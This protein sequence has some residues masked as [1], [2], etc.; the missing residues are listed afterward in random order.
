V[1]TYTIG[2]YN[3]NPDITDAL[4][5]GAGGSII[6]GI[7]GNGLSFTV[8]T[9]NADEVLSFA[10]PSPPAPDSPPFAGQYQV[11]YAQLLAA[12]LNVLRGATCDFATA[13]IAAANTFLADSPPGGMMG[14]DAVQQ[15]LATFNQG[16]AEGCPGLCS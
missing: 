1:C 5:T 12:N 13:A 3:N 8:T 14:A 2:F 16:L 11:L 6:L 9:A 4:I 15:P 10:T 7:N